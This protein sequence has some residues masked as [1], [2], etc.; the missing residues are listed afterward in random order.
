VKPIIPQ[1]KRILF[2]KDFSKKTRHAFRYAG[3]LA[4]QLGASIAILYVTY[5]G[6]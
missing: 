5:I 3:S 6:D 2:T 1:I 4:I